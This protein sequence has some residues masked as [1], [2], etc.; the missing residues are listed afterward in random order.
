MLWNG[1]ALEEFNPMIF[2][3]NNV[4]WRVKEEIQMKCEFQS[5]DNLDKYLGVFIFYSSPNKC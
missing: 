3:Y 5:L 4:N 2:F 1:E